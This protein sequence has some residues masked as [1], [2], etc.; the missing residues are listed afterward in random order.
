MLGGGGGGWVGRVSS[1]FLFVL[2]IFSC[3]KGACWTRGVE[4]TNVLSDKLRA[5]PGQ[6]TAR[7]SRRELKETV[8]QLCHFQRLVQTPLVSN[9]PQLWL[10][11][12]STSVHYSHHLVH[13]PSR[14]VTRTFMGNGALVCFFTDPKRAEQPT[15]SISVPAVSVVTCAG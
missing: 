15:P 13:F 1:T 11:L 8:V 2:V 4:D 10:W 9:P 7:R 14:T 3:L 12:L 5:H 6:T